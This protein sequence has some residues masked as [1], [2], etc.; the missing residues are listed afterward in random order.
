MTSQ[1]HP[2]ATHLLAM[3][4]HMPRMFQTIKYLCKTTCEPHEGPII[5]T[6]LY[7]DRSRS[8]AVIWMGRMRPLMEVLEIMKVLN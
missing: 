3:L 6:D 4:F 5:T 8:A 1:N 7:P 2:Q